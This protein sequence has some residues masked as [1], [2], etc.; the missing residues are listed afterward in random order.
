MEVGKSAATS[1]SITLTA[2]PP[3]SMLLHVITGGLCE[4]H[5]DTTRA[6]ENCLRASLGESKNCEMRLT[7][8]KA[9]IP[10]LF[11]EVSLNL[12]R[13]WAGWGCLKRISCI[14]IAGAWVYNFL[15]SF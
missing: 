7:D 10:Y 3:S 13:F 11:K 14:K 6:G 8:N 5:T 9:V 1:A 2:L 12:L 4:K 15:I